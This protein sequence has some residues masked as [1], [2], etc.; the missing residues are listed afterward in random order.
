MMMSITV[1]N[2]QRYGNSL[3]LRFGNGNQRTI[4]LSYNQHLFKYISAEA[5]L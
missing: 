5:I 2:A 1:V 4:G 3:G